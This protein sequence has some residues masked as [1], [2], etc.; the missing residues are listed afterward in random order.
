MHG[1]DDENNEQQA[2]NKIKVEESLFRANNTHEIEDINKRAIFKG[3]TV[4]QP[5]TDAS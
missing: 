4:R 5:N 1:D 3:L 2:R